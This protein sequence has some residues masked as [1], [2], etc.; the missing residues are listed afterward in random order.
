MGIFKIKRRISKYI[1]KPI[2][3]IIK[4]KLNFRN[5]YYGERDLSTIGVRDLKFVRFMKRV[6]LK[7]FPY[8]F[9]T[10]FST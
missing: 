5:I 4:Y 1:T 3:N 9:F 6:S 7:I 10:F 2:T 8:P